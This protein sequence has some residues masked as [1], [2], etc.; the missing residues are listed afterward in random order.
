MKK[1]VLIILL[2]LTSCSIGPTIVEE[3]ESEIQVYFCPQDFC[4]EKIIELIDKSTD[5]KCAFYDLD[6][7]ELINTLKQ[8]NAHVIL[9]DKNA[10]NEFDTGYSY[11]LMHNKFCVFDNSTVFTGSMN[12]TV[13]GNYYNNNNIVIIK[14]KALARNYLDEFDEL[15]NNIYGSGSKVK[16]PI[17]KMGETKIESYFCPEDSCKLRVINTL[18]LAN[19]SIYF[20]TFS[21]TD[22]DIGNLL[23]NK[24]YLGLD[25]KGMLEK[26]QISDYSRY[27]D[28][29]EF[30][31]I[32]KNKYT[33]HH[34][35]FVI[36]EKIVITGSYNPTKNANENNDENILIIHDKEIAKQYIYEFNKQYNFEVNL[37]KE[38]AGVIISKIMYDVIGSDKGNEYVELKNIGQ[39]N[40]N[41]DYYFLT[42]N[43][44]NSR[45]NG[46]LK[47]NQTIKV[48]PKFSFKNSNGQLFLKKHHNIIDY[49]YWEGIWNIDAEE[50]EELIRTNNKIEQG[51]WRGY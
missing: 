19:E 1:Y 31:I 46:T 6:L 3:Q 5:I 34:K 27:E 40:V 14:S 29:K 11:A 20:M 33:F 36:D 45:L 30:S 26:K 4:Q 43:K 39:N 16:N 49:V 7:P 48:M 51:S 22:E 12:P 8:K 37:P 42:D 23:W 50:G 32:D 25:V 10:L 18:N 13:R 15:E 44:T 9:E 24:N 2:I 17:I 38:T 41:L 21:F 47:V 28:L 35:V